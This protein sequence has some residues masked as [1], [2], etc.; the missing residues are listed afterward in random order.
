M[1]EDRA[2]LVLLAAARNGDHSAFLTI[3]RRYGTRIFR[4]L[5]RFLGSAQAAEDITHDCFLDLL[6]NPAKPSA[7][8]NNSV[9]IQLYSTARELAMERSQKYV[10]DNSPG[11]DVEEES[12][13]TIKELIKALPPLERETL[14]L[15]EYEGLSARDVAQIV[16]ADNEAVQLR[17]NGAREKLRATLSREAD[18]SNEQ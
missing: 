9:L 6:R 12:V 16:K 11:S 13:E 7:T 10:E 8:D 3:F 17:L 5:Y 1:N 18:T 2:D 14:I 4:F 15:F